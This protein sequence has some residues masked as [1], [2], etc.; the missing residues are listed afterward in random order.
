MQDVLPDAERSHQLVLVADDEKEARL[1]LRRILEREDF[2]VE[3]ASD[4]RM[5]VEKAQALLPDLIFLDIQMPGIDGFE[6]VQ[7][8]RSD[9][10]TER[11]PVIVV[12]AAAREPR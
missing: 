4:G 8:L 11:I 10:R 5:T 7:L 3:E 1:L 9:P 6:A 2:R 12:S